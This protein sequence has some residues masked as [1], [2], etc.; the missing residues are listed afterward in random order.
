MS[1]QP[2]GDRTKYVGVATFAYLVTPWLIKYSGMLEYT[3]TVY[4]ALM[5]LTALVTAAIG[6]KT[7]R[8]SGTV[9]EG[10]TKA[11]S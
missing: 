4:N 6:S 2:V 11:S 7:Y 5:A 10:E 1:G 9:R 8:P 3:S